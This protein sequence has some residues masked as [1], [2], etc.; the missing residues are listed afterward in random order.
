MRESIAKAICTIQDILAADRPKNIVDIICHGSLPNEDSGIHFVAHYVD[1]EGCDFS[2][3]QYIKYHQGQFSLPIDDETVKDSGS[4]IITKNC[5]DLRRAENTWTI[6]GQIASG[7]S[8]MHGKD[9]LHKALKPG[10]GSF[11]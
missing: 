3:E 6:G 2:L 9:I 4:A 8:S 5:S 10:H 1:L 11:F 7:L